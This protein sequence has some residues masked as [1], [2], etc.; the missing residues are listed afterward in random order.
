M[1][2]LK[3]KLN[4][5][6]GPEWSTA[7][8][9]NLDLCTGY[10][11][12]TQLLTPFQD[13]SVSKI[14]TS[15]ALE[16]LKIQSVLPLLKECFRVLCPGGVIRI[17]VPDVELHIRQ[18]QTH[19]FYV[20]V[21]K[22]CFDSPRDQIIHM[23]G[24]PEDLN[25]PSKIGHYF[26]YDRYSI[27]WLLMMAGFANPYFSTHGNSSDPELRLTVPPDQSP[28]RFGFDHPGLIAVSCYVEVCK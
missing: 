2:D 1:I 11:L 10:D 22:I 18:A 8:W 7:G 24:N 19:E 13:H 9:L 16:H 26:F 25:K 4:L 17:V 12:E 20:G 27:S 23:G 15:H 6:G 21:N 3:R 28:A 14:Y 5:G